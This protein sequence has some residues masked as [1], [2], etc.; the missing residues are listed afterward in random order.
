MGLAE[1][2]AKD[3]DDYVNI[4]MRIAILKDYR[5]DLANR[6]SKTRMN[7]FGQQVRINVVSCDALC[8][9]LYGVMWLKETTVHILMKLINALLVNGIGCSECL[10]RILC[11]FSPESNTRSGH[12]IYV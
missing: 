9:T 8:D 6:L 7:L 4:A 12:L 11:E 1:L 10:G 3:A 5:K 2:I